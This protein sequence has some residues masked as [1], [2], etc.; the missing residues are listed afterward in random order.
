MAPSSFL[1][2][3]SELRYTIY[4]HL[5]PHSPLSYPYKPP[6]PI[7]SISVRG[8][9]MS[10][11]LSNR[12]ILS[13][14]STYYFTRCTFRFVAQSFSTRHGDLTQSSLQIVRKMRRI[15]ILLL[16]GTMRAS[17]PL[18]PAESQPS[19]NVKQMSADWL[20]EKIALLRDE[21]RELR[22]VVV[23]IR[24]VSW[25]YEWSVEGEMEALL[26]PMEAL[27]GMV[28][29]RIGEVMGPQEVERNMRVALGTVLDKLNNCVGAPGSVAVPDESKYDV[30]S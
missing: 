19:L 27:R 28:E 30:G 20:D 16:P 13:E 11:V 1:N 17:T 10:L 7:T 18:S 2:L 24:R 12:A 6:S 29:F 4:D 9:P 23:S 21:A 22:V 8:P 25:N 5:C 15:E 26:K 3:P 14:L